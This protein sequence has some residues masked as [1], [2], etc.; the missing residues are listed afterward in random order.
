M[1]LL[2]SKPLAP[3]LLTSAG[4]KV[5]LDNGMPENTDDSNVPEISLF[6]AAFIDSLSYG[7]F[8]SARFTFTFLS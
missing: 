1:G 5:F 8:A 6:V 4:G 7:G 2:S 3:L